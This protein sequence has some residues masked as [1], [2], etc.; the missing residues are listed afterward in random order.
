MPLYEF[1]GRFFYD[2]VNSNLLIIKQQES[3][4]KREGTVFN[5]LLN[6]PTCY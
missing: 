1:I 5:F 2:K 6:L 4:C 3:T